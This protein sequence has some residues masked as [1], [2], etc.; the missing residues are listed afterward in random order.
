[1]DQSRRI[2]LGIDGGGTKTVCVAISPMRLRVEPGA[3]VIP[4]ARIEVG[5]TNRNSVGPEQAYG[6][7]QRVIVQALEAAGRDTA[8]VDAVCLGMSGVDRP[9][10]LALMEAW[11]AEL[12]P[13]VPAIIHNDA[14]IALASGS[15]GA[16]FGVVLISGTGMIA[17]GFNHAGER[18]RA[19]GWGA[20]LGDGGSG[21]AIGAAVLRAI[22]WAADGRDART[23][24]TDMTL[25][26]LQMERAQQ[27]VRWTYDDISW[28]RIAEL[29][30]LALRAAEAGDP[31]AVA[32]VRTA[33]VD[34]A[35]AA[36]AVARRLK[37]RSTPF[38]LV[39]SGGNLRSGMLADALEERF[40]RTL[41]SAS[42]VHPSLEPAIGAALLAARSRSATV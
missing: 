15:S 11:M 18:Q 26:H 5:S 41:P 8:D 39:L 6:Q 20:L 1:M 36:E 7:L 27:L 3:T 42:I 25:A 9:E 32:I 29:A 30:P 24:L 35:L 22:T 37:L 13:G 14:V 2:V 40:R 34:L 23:M 28:R 4:A 33:V 21:Y 38:P 31:A 16:L 19:G 17:M 10:D 12:L